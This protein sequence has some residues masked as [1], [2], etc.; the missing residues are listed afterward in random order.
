M[1]EAVTQSI[2]TEQTAARTPGRRLTVIA[3]REEAA[4]PGSRFEEVLGSALD[5]REWRRVEKEEELRAFLRERSKRGADE[6]EEEPLLFALSLGKTGINLEYIRMLRFLR[7]H[8]N[9]LEGCVGGA[10]VDGRSDLY[11][12]SVARELVFTANRAG[13]AFVGRPLVEGTKTLSNF[14]IVAR[15]MDTDLLSA[16]KK[17]AAIL[18]DEILEFK[19]PVS[20]RPS[21]LV[22]HA[23]SH[24]NSNTFALWGVCCSFS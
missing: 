15:N 2:M 17:S 13:C 24:P 12:K 22:L 9:A 21:L 5:G 14:S 20:E 11:T 23:S 4:A 7:E 19:R 1:E 3:P 16:Y 6:Q 8:T 10:L 18:T